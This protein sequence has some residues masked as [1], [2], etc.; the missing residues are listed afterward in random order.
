MRLA[1]VLLSQVPSLGQ[2]P[3]QLVA[4]FYALPF[5]VGLIAFRTPIYAFLRKRGWWDAFRKALPAELISANLILLGIFP[6]TVLTI[7]WLDGFPVPDASYPVNPLFWLV[8]VP[9]MLIG[10][11]ITYPVHRWMV[12]TGLVPW[13]ALAMAGRM[14]DAAAAE[15]NIS[16]GKILLAVL[17]TTIILFGVVFWLMSLM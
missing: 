15:P 17:L 1:F 2:T 11:A 9:A 8:F 3:P 12:K 5:L 16:R 10:L 4:F 14:G 6:V 7:N 13:R